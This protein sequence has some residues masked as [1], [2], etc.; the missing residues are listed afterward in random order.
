MSRR[1]NKLLTGNRLKCLLFKDA[2]I[3]N[4]E[5]QINLKYI[6]INKDE[7]WVNQTKLKI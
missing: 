2:I 5:I 7:K 6:I 3:K 4:E 1:R